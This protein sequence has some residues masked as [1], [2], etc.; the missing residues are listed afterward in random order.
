MFWDILYYREEQDSKEKENESMGPEHT[1]QNLDSTDDE[2]I[3][4]CLEV[5]PQEV[6]IDIV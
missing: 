3:Q 5:V 2:T 4:H 1:K 6:K